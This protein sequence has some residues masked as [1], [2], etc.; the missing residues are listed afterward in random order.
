MV[1]FALFLCALL[2]SVTNFCNANATATANATPNAT[3]SNAVTAGD[4]LYVSAQVPVDPNTGVMIQG[5]V[6][7]L[8][9]QA[10]SNLYHVVLLKGFTMKQVVKTTV[11]LTDIRD[12]DTMNA[13]YANWFPYQYPPARDVM[14]VSNLPFNARLQVSCVAYKKK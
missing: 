12:Y 1:R 3:Y 5:D 2:T 6:E 11:Y 8:M 9:N 4:Y 7:E 14:A 13:T 10:M